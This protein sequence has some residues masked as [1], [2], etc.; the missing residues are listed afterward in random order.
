MKD[1]SVV[2]CCHNS[3][4]RIAETIRHIALQEVSDEVEW[5]VIVVNNASAD[6]TSTM[7]NSAWQKYYQGSS[8]RFRVINESQAGLAHARSA[9]IINAEADIVIFCDDDNHL[10]QDY[11]VQALLILSKY[12]DV[13]IIGGW[14]KPKFSMEAEPWLEDLYPALAIGPQASSEGFVS[15]VYGAGMV[16]KKKIFQD[17]KSRNIELV[18]SDRVG[19]KQTSGGDCEICQLAGY[20]SYKIYYSPKLQLFHAIGS[21]RLSQKSFIKAN[22]RNVYPIVYLYLL[23]SLIANRAASV[24]W[25]YVSFWRKSVANVFYFIPRWLLGK[26][27]FYSFILL[28]QNVQLTFWMLLNRSRFTQTF[29][30]IKRNLA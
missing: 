18:L 28:Y 22:Y 13:G 27:R 25:L 9:G 20:L 6:N 24:N 4:H 1:I 19:L 15:W 11:L 2:V 30:R 26:H 3:E 16:V 29:F 10:A 14:A 17:F 7:A 21:H 12:P 5:E 8:A 23:Q